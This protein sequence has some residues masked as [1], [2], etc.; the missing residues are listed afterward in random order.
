MKIIDTKL[1]GVKIL[2]PDIFGDE[3]GSFVK[4]FHKE[5]FE[6]NGLN[7]RFEESFYSISKKGVIRGMHFQTPPADHV[8]LVY[9]PAGAIMD[10]VV[11]IRKNSP[12]YGQYVNVELSQNNGTMIYIPRGCA[13]GFIA[14]ED[15][16]AAVYMQE[17]MRSAEHEGGIRYDSFGMDWGTE[18]PI[19][20]K[21]DQIFPKLSEF[22]SP[23][24]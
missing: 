9:C 14:L 4:P 12:T 20:S 16:S 17:T 22:N 5:T 2:Q 11:D 19:L 3:R 6:K 10:V 21:R 24:N 13:H 8:K 1:E 15:N 18:T 7:T 23:F